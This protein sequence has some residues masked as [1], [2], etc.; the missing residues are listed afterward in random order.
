VAYEEIDTSDRENLLSWG[1]DDA[2]YLDDKPFRPDAPPW[3][4]DELRAEILK[5]VKNR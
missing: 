1:I 4:S 2:V 5:V 3:T